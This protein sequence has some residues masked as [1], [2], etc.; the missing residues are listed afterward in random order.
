[1]WVLVYNLVY[2][3]YYWYQ[4]FT[5]F[6]HLRIIGFQY[7]IVQYD[8]QTDTGHTQANRNV[9][10]YSIWT[11]V[12]NSGYAKYWQTVSTDTPRWGGSY[13]SH[14][15]PSV[16]C[17]LS[18]QGFQH[19]I[20]A[21]NIKSYLSS[22]PLSSVPNFTWIRQKA[23]L[24]AKIYGQ[25]PN[26]PVSLTYVSHT[27]KRSN[28]IHFQKRVS[29]IEI[30]TLDEDK[31]GK[32]VKYCPL[33][34]NSKLDLR[35]KF[36]LWWIRGFPCGSAGKEFACHAEDLGLILGLGRAPGKGKG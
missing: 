12:P 31:N 15:R 25:F 29:I 24:A 36:L 7:Q 11:A 27:L 35:N 16:E 6:Y 2:I 34:S 18:Q 26:M 22:N 17:S 3:K 32:T 14:Q 13:T 19:F 20:C 30:S 33:V 4:A 21:G 1:M 9:Y 10:G 28:H 23:T 5:N 8:S